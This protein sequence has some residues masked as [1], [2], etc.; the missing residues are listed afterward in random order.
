LFFSLCILNFRNLIF[1]PLLFSC[2]SIV[3]YSLSCFH[4]PSLSP[5]IFS[6]VVYLSVLTLLCPDFPFVPL[7]LKLTIVGRINKAKYIVA[8]TGAGVSASAGLGTFRGVGKGNACQVREDLFDCVFPTF[9]HLALNEMLRSGQIKHIV[10]SNH[11]NLHIKA[12]A[13][14]ADVSELFGNGYVETCLKC[15][16]QFRRTTVC[17]SLNRKCEE[18]GGALKKSGVRYGQ[19]VPEA[20]TKAGFEQAKKCDLALVFGSGMHTGPFCDMPPLAKQFYLGLSCF[21]F[22]S[23][24]IN[25]K[26]NFIFI[27]IFKSQ[28]GSD[29]SRSS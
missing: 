5:Q 23:I 7:F 14:E 17:P 2:S 27:F 21:C 20:P 1:F 15:K 28:F 12:G 24:S 13:N 22:I 10:T 4:S 18:C 11:D 26:K 3:S 8:F 6:N 19:R 9:S 25:R 29:K 16:K